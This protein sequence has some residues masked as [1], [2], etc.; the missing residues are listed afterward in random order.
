MLSKKICVEL[1]VLQA[2]K[3]K[4]LG[5]AVNSASHWKPHVVITTRHCR[6]SLKLL[7]VCNIWRDLWESQRFHSW[8][9]SI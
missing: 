6:D 7:D 8:R 9:M 3:R 2:V 1:H 5:S 4:A